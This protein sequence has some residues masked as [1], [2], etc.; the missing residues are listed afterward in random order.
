MPSKHIDTSSKEPYEPKLGL[1]KDSTAAWYVRRLPLCF[2]RIM[3]VLLI[4]IESDFGRLL[5]GPGVVG[6]GAKG[7]VQLV[8][9]PLDV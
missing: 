3:A 4:L 8:L 5:H 6:L 2:D 9:L 7:S 1:N